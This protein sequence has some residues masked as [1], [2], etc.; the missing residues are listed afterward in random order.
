MLL[1]IDDQDHPAISEHEAEVQRSVAVYDQQLSLLLES[2]TL[3][4]EIL[5]ALTQGP[6]PYKFHYTIAFYKSILR[7]ALGK[8][9]IKKLEE[10]MIKYH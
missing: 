6:T 2:K 10:Y 3:K 1:A 9:G 7:K 4:D 5:L 8:G